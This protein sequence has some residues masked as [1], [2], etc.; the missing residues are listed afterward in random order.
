MK[1]WKRIEP[2][3]VQKV[4]YRTIVT[5]TFQLPNGQIATFDTMHAE[6]QEFVGVIALTPDNKVVVARMFRFGPELVM[7][8]IPGGF[9]DKGETPDESVRRELLE[10]TGYEAGNIQY[11]GASHKDT[12]MNA[13]WHYFLA[14]DCRQSD[15][16]AEHTP[17]AEENIEVDLITIDRLIENAKQDRMTDVVAVLM[18]Y[19]E[20]QKRRS[21]S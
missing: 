1:P 21:A 15:H 6:D 7:E 18:A 11:L 5:K 2:T 14:T 12:Y 13:T 3:T 17:E 4:G 8:E 19:D 20:L 16:E 10:E 9:V